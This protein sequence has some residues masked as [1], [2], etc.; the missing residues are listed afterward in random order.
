MSQTIETDRF[1]LRHFER[2]DAE[3]GETVNRVQY[4][5]MEEIMEIKIIENNKKDFLDLLLLADEQESMIDKYLERGTLFAL[6]DDSLKSICVVTDEGNNTFEIQNLATYEQFQGQGY[7][8]HLV[9]YVCDYYKNKGETMLVGTGDTPQTVS[10]YERCGFAFSHRLENY[11]LEHYDEPIFEAGVQ[12]KDK[13]YFKMNLRK[14]TTESVFDRCNE[15][16]NGG[17]S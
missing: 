3:S 7:G 2:A 14:N 6:Y 1:I 5:M 15:K 12:L 4:G 8:R 16:G 11:I 13:V 10:F 9:K 17:F